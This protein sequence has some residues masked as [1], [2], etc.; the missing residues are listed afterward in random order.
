MEHH[1]TLTEGVFG[2]MAHVV[3]FKPDG[4][5]GKEARPADIHDVSNLMVL[6]T[7]C[8]KLIDDHPQRFSRLTLE[9]FKAAHE[10]HIR[11][12][13]SLLPE[14][15]TAVLTLKATIGDQH[16]VI[17][18]AHIF[19]AV[20]PRYPQSRQGTV[21]DLTNLGPEGDA[22]L[23]AGRVAIRSRLEWLLQSP[24][25]ELAKT[26]HLSVF[27]LGPMPLLMYL[28]SQLSNKVPLELYQRH[29]DTESWTW[30]M[31]GPAVR[32][33]VHRLREG[34]AS[35]RVA[36]IL[37][38]SSNIATDRLPSS[39]D[40]QYSVY[41][42][43]LDGLGPSPTFLRRRE[44]LTE[45]RLAYQDLL[46]RLTALHP[47]LQEIHIFPAVPAPVAVLCGRERLPKVHPALV[48]YDS[49]KGRGGFGFRLRID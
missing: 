20:S 32:Y 25:S 37:S 18:A 26:G 28:G 36:I 4:P 10:A 27:A 48:V 46:S 3:A 43:T 17:P 31:D 15:R 24:D 19:E 5:R 35:D 45:F 30:K 47:G 39:I 34:A 8:H 14:H 16:V 33:T 42:L 21:I 2:Q 41:E 12:V 49:D 29:R 1:V 11:Q 23:Q 22:A 9:Q 13:T 6:C 7:D 38:L 40:E 44:D